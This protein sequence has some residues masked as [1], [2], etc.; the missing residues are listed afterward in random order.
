MVSSNRRLVILLLLAAAVL[1]A[2]VPIN[3]RAIVTD[4]F[5]EAFA[6]AEAHY[7][8]KIDYDRVTSASIL[9]MLRALD[10]HSDYDTREEY[11]ELRSQQQSEYFGIGATVAQRQNKVYIISPFAN[12]PAMRAGLKY[13]DQIVEVDGQST[14]GWNSAKV[15]SHLKGPRGTQV[16]VKVL[17]PGSSQPIEVSISRAAVSLPSITNAY[18]IKPGIGYIWLQRSFARTS[19]EEM[20][21]AVAKLK[22]Q[23]MKKLILDLRDNGGGLVQAA[24]D[25]LE[26]FI[27]QGQVL[28]SV[29]GRQEVNNRTLESRNPAPETFPLA[30]VINNA[31][32]SASEIVAGALQ[33]HD[34]A[35]IIGETSFG[36]GLVQTIF[37][38]SEGAALRLTTAKYYT[39]SGR[40]IQRSYDGN[41][42][43]SYYV[44]RGKN[45]NSDRPQFKT[46]SG[47]PVYG[48]GGITPDIVVKSRRLTTNQIKL[49]EPIFLFTRELVNG[50]VKGLESFKVDNVNFNHVLR[51]DEFRISDQ[52]LEA[53]KLFLQNAGF[54]VRYS[55]SIVD[56]NREVVRMLIR[57]EVVTAACGSETARQV[58]IESDPQVLRA[59]EE[60]EKK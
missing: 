47:R 38:L 41:S 58:F 33:D 51:P 34:R 42:L 8:G 31:S 15:S 10:P 2:A 32:A 3:D 45:D 17:R 1:T 36:K 7:A 43:Y 46:D 19:A 27:P 29:K 9:G 53:F 48:S 22:Q 50:Q 18:M 37:P 56:D 24:L 35:I 49:Q 60:L 30:V 44:N 21:A 54:E 28:L 11:M 57:A 16:R 5:L 13:G 39:P 20:T 23:N 14:E 59:I 26:M 4:S 52:V 6:L 55:P 12:T 40:L 25:I